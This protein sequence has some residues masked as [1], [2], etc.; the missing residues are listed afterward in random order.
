MSLQNEDFIVI[1]HHNPR[2]LCFGTLRSLQDPCASDH[3]FLDGTFKSCPSP[4]AQLYTI[5]VYSSILNG[6]VP[7]LYCLLPNK[8]KKMYALLFNELRTVAIQ[9]ELVLNPKF[10]TFDFEQGAIGALRNVFPNA[11]IKGCNF[12]YSQCVFKKIQKLGL[13]RDYLNS[14]PDDSTSVK[15]LI[16]ET[17]AL[18]FI[19]LDDIN[20]L[21]CG[22]MD[23]FDHIPRVQDFFDYFTDTWIEDGC[24]FPRQLLELLQ[25]QTHV[26]S[27]LYTMTSLRV[28]TT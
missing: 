12:H 21:W 3:I 20:D 6:T 7:L 28:T 15:C 9:H 17:S 4:F 23:K 1:D 2:Y 13:Q 14:S 25:L 11:S 16:Q 10:T 22:I 24:L 5:H 26:L 18:A 19:P 27:F 8:T